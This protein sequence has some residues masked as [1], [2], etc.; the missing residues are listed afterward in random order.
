MSIL[1]FDDCLSSSHDKKAVAPVNMSKLLSFGYAE[2][3]DKSLDDDASSETSCFFFITLWVVHCGYHVQGSC[4]VAW[5][6]ILKACQIIS[7]NCET[8]LFAF[9]ILGITSEQTS[10]TAPEDELE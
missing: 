7:Y 8:N 10:T 2:E 5:Y 3:E 1:V 6:E 9:D 4:S